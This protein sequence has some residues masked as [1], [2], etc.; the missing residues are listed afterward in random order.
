MKERYISQNK[1]AKDV[2]VSQPY[3]HKLVK[4]GVFKRCM[5]DG[6]LVRDCAVEAFKRYQAGGH[7][8][9]NA[10][11][12]PVNF[13]PPAHIKRSPVFTSDNMMQVE[14][15]MAEVEDPNRRVQLM[16]DFWAAKLNEHKALNLAATL[17]DREEAKRAADFI[18]MQFQEKAHKMVEKITPALAVA[19]TLPQARALLED[20]IYDMLNELA[21]LQYQ[22]T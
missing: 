22:P 3:I 14:Q 20:A 18:V 21:A 16:R 7:V 13:E 6:K 9:R 5:E 12:A 2:G 4:R 8:K 19:E 15:L 1:L 17:V 10:K 11:T